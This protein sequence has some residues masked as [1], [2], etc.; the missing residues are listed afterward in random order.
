[1]SDAENCSCGLTSNECI[2]GGIV[3]DYLGG[4]SKLS[5]I[6]SD[7]DVSDDVSEDVSDSD[8]SD[9]DVSDSDVSDKVDGGFFGDFSG[10]SY[11]TKVGGELGEFYALSSEFTADNGSANDIS[12]FGNNNINSKLNMVGGDGITN[13]SSGGEV[14]SEDGGIIESEDE[15]KTVESEGGGIIETDDEVESEGGGIIETD[16][17][18]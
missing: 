11:D 13:Y 7:S 2:C 18:V 8:G 6:R 9:S 16:D 10:D 5:K 14:E 3:L 1:M 12:G 17:E 15:V 4:N